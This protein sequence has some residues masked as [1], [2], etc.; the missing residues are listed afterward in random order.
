M[1]VFVVGI[2]PAIIAN[3]AGWV[4]A[5]VG[6]QPW[7]VH[8]PMQVDDQGQL[9]RNEAGQIIYQE[10]KGLRTSNAVS[11]AIS[12]EQV[13]SSIIMFSVIYLLLGAVWLFVLNRKIQKGPVEGL[14][15][16]YD[17]DAKDKSLIDAATSTGSRTGN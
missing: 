13:L 14:S 6:R 5:E 12:A 9:V 11:K 10:D 7:I 16:G 1:M 4:A 3:E 17:S 15:S 2:I 8:P